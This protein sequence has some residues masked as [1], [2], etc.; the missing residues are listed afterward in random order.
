MNI[1]NNDFA[2]KI[3]TDDGEIKSAED[4]QHDYDPTEPFALVCILQCN[5]D[6]SL[7]NE[8]VTNLRTIGALPNKYKE[9][10]LFV[11]CNQSFS[12]EQLRVLSEMIALELNFELQLNGIFHRLFPYHSR[13]IPIRLSLYL[14][15]QLLKRLKNDQ[16]SIIHQLET[17]AENIFNARY[18]SRYEAELRDGPMESTTCYG[19]IETASISFHLEGDD[20]TRNKWTV[21]EVKKQIA[22]H[23]CEELGKCLETT[24]VQKFR[25]DLN[26]MNLNFA[27][28]ILRTIN[29]VDVKQTFYRFIVVQIFTYIWHGFIQMFSVVSTFVFG[30]SLNS[31]SFRIKLAYN[32]HLQIMKH[33]SKILSDVAEQFKTVLQKHLIEIKNK[34]VEVALKLD[35]LGAP[36]I[37]DCFY[38][39]LRAVAKRNPFIRAISYEQDEISIFITE[40]KYTEVQ[41]FLSMYIKDAQRIKIC[42]FKNYSIKNFENIMTSGD[43]VIR[44]EQNDRFGTVGILLKASQ[45]FFGTTCEHVTRN[46]RPDQARILLHC[47]QLVS[48]E[49]IKIPSESLDFSVIQINQE[50]L[51]V[52][53]HGGIK[54]KNGDYYPGKLLE[55]DTITLPPGKAVYKWGA[56]SKLTTGRYIGTFED[57]EM[58]YVLHKIENDD[59]SEQFAFP[60][61]SGSLVCFTQE[62]EVAAFMVMGEFQLK[63]S[64]EPSCILCIRVADGLYLTEKIIPN[65]K[66]C[67]SKPEIF[68][69][70]TE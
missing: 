18:L 31:R 20:F 21:D 55:R 43:K 6:A 12:S 26:Q 3:P 38:H 19:I 67:L 49:D 28:Y 44:G 2:V 65:I 54:N 66:H 10:C 17:V 33:K 14:E 45:K 24:L 39:E 60:G 37:R 8:D 27:P 11:T 62:N 68:S 4:R 42:E 22:G 59:S 13:E 48:S 61:D 35:E 40:Q 7:T 25:S 5:E 69:L 46:L 23:I 41:Q 1:D 64:E 30:E 56:A 15:K 70:R 51:D 29:V 63:D 57:T 9:Q 16:I 34:T 53:L 50:T 47:G 52:S 36:N 32:V 58:P